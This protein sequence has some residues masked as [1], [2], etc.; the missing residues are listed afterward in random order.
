MCTL[1]LVGVDGVTDLPTRYICA[2]RKNV[3]FVVEYV[4]AIT[5]FKTQIDAALSTVC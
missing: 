3:S 1:V 2:V 4:L 5:A